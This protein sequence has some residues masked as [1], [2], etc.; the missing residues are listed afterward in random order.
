MRSASGG[1][2]LLAVSGEPVAIP[3]VLVE[4]AGKLSGAG[5]ENGA[6]AFKEEDCHQV[7]LRRI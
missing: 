2:F 5:A 3:E 6:A 4:L 7:P 1:S